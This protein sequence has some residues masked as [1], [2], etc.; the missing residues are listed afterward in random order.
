MELSQAQPFRW[1]NRRDFPVDAYL[2][3]V[4]IDLDLWHAIVSDHLPFRNRPAVAHRLDLSPQA[5]L[6]VDAKRVAR[7]RDERQAGARDDRGERAKHGTVE[8]WLTGRQRGVWIAHGRPDDHST[9]DD[10]FRLRAKA[11]DRPQHDVG[12]FSRLQTAD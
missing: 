10:H 6:L 7:L 11:A 9:L 5:K 12:E 1:R 3:G 8:D 4:R 2:I